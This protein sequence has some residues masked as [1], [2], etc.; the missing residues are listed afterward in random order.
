M[1]GDRP[2]SDARTCTGYSAAD[3]QPS[4][5]GGPPRDPLGPLR[6]V[7]SSGVSGARGRCGHD[8]W[9]THWDRFFE[10]AQHIQ[11]GCRVVLVGTF[12]QDLVEIL[13]GQEESFVPWS[14]LSDC[15]KARQLV[16]WTQC[17]LVLEYK[18]S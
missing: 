2:I 9:G 15:W 14:L 5:V 13:G 8:P 4:A 11:W 7:P 18:R 1:Y 10:C 6:R 17:P 16:M 3:L 12:M